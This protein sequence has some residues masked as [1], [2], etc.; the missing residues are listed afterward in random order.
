M[1]LS[2]A[3]ERIEAETIANAEFDPGAGH[4]LHQAHGAARRDRVLVPATLNLHHSTDPA[5]RDGEATGRLVD[6][7]GEPIDGLQNASQ[8]VR[9]R[10]ARR[11]SEAAIWHTNGAMATMTRTIVGR[12]RSRAIEPASS[13]I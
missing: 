10:S 8:S 7:F 4:E 9:A 3:I 11:A 6:E 2:R 12:E 13:Q 1:M 5:R